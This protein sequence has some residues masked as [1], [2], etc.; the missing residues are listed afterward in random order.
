[1]V[2]DEEEKLQAARSTSLH[3]KPGMKA[4][5]NV[6]GAR[7][8]RLIDRAKNHRDDWPAYASSRPMLRA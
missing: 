8:D 1:M 7:Y 3:G 4:G 2:R 5:S 6:I